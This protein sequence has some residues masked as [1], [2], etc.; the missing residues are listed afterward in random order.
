MARKV[1]IPHVYCQA[2][3]SP[4]RPTNKSLPFFLASGTS[5]VPGL[6]VNVDVLGQKQMAV[7][8]SQLE[9]SLGSCHLGSTKL[10]FL[11][12]NEFPIIEVSTNPIASIS[13]FVSTTPIAISEPFDN[14]IITRHPV[15]LSNLL[16]HHVRRQFHSF[17]LKIQ[18]LS[19][20]GL[21]PPTSSKRK[22]LL[23]LYASSPKLRIS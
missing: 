17:L 5:A 22:A 8:A 11:A 2:L 12:V 9:C 7:F 10:D 16:P 4:S 19:R 20:G 18:P 15:I 1:S 6:G 14:D 23:L 21:A 13:V 3:F